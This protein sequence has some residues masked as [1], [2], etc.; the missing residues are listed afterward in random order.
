MAVTGGDGRAARR[1]DLAI[2]QTPAARRWPLLVTG[3]GLVGIVVTAPI[4][5]TGAN[6]ISYGHFYW[7]S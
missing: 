3:L 4:A 5:A 1:T 2:V 6:K 7:L